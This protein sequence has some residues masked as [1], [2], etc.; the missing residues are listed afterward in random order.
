MHGP[1]THAAVCLIRVESQPSGLLISLIITR[2]V[3]LGGP[4]PSR[5]FSDADAA[6][7]VV[8]DF[9]RS[10]TQDGTERGA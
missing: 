4:E 9:L 8:A 2:D 10:M 1:R 7:D 3:T 6:A 5:H